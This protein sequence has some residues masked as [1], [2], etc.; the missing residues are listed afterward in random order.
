MLHCPGCNR[1]IMTQTKE[2][3]KVRSRMVL[4]IEDYAEAICPTCKKRVKVPLTL[5]NV[6]EVFELPKLVLQS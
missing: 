2:G 1:I 6:E 4:F 5:G 3:Y